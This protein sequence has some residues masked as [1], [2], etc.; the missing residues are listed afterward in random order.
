MDSYYEIISSLDFVANF[1]VL[2][3]LMF[4][5]LFVF[6]DGDFSEN[7]TTFFL[8][9]G[10]IGVFAGDGFAAMF[11]S[12]SFVLFIAPYSIGDAVIATFEIFY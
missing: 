10:I 4:T 7:I 1:F 8:L 5:S 2:F 11:D 6:T 9:L 12:I 3:L